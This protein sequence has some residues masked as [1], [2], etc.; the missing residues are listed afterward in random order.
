MLVEFRFKNFRSFA[1][2]AFVQFDAVTAFK[3]E[4]ENLI[5]TKDGALL[6]SIAV[7]GANASGKSNIVAALSWMRSLVLQS[8]KKNSILARRGRDRVRSGRICRGSK[9]VAEY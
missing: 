3:E 8:A 2:E 7:Y 1:D 4:S 6:K 9:C 5:K